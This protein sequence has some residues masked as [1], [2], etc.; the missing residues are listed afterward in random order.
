MVI[1]LGVAIAFRDHP[2]L[3]PGIGE[4]VAQASAGDARCA[5][6]PS[7]PYGRSESCGYV[8]QGFAP[9]PVCDG[10]CLAHPYKYHVN[11]S[12]KPPA[13]MSCEPPAL[14]ICNSMIE[15]AGCVKQ[16]IRLGQPGPIILHAFCVEVTGLRGR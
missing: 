4:V 8:L 12:W 6:L 15:G 9:D 10:G 14:R 3:S 1:V 16:S 13:R 11:M 5:A 7:G 2:G